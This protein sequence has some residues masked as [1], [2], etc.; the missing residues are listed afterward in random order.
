[1]QEKYYVYN[2][3][4]CICLFVGFVTI[5]NCST[6]GHGLLEIDLPVTGA[7]LLQAFVNYLC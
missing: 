6:H 5:S 7:N 1:M 2:I 3:I 4:L